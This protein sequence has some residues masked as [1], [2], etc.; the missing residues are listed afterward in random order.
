MF[1]LNPGATFAHTLPIPVPGGNLVDIKL[2]FRRMP[3][4]EALAYFHPPSAD[5][6]AGGQPATQEPR[7]D[8]D[9]VSGLISGWEEVDA[10]FSREA[11]AELLEN[12]P[13][14]AKRIADAYMP[15]LWGAIEKN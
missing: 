11:L 13:Q 3:R 4:A 5:A 10:P 12:Y 1:K 7:S 6:S 2:I 8:L 9:F 15:A 14:A